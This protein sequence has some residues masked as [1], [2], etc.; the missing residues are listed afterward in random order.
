M[1][2]S[3]RTKGKQGQPNRY[4]SQP[5]LQEVWKTHIEQNWTLPLGLLTRLTKR[6]VY[7]QMLLGLRGV[8]GHIKKP[9]KATEDAPLWSGRMD[10]DIGRLAHLVQ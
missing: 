2:G 6:Q 10:L 3:K 4:K 8:L 1:M 5:M 9:K 7:S